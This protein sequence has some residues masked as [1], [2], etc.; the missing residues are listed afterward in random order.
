MYLSGAKSL[1]FAVISGAVTT[2]A[3]TATGQGIALFRVMFRKLLP[4]K[5]LHR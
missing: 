3:T 4:P 1:A 5:A 2:Q